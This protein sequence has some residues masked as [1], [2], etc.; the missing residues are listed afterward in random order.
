MD[1]EMRQNNSLVKMYKKSKNHILLSQLKI[2]QK[3][4]VSEW[5]LFNVNEQFLSYVMG[6]TS[7]LYYDKMMM[8][9][10]LH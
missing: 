6:R 7:K 1:G 10:T 5:L 2:K 9:S 3:V 8:M 4:W